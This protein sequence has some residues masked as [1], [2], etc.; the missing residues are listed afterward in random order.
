M[1]N[2]REL[3][4]TPQE[5][6]DIL[7]DLSQLVEVC[8]VTGQEKDL[9]LIL[10]EKL[11]NAGFDQVET[12]EVETGRL[13]VVAFLKGGKPGPRILFTG[14]MDTVPA[15]EGWTLAPFAPTVRDGR[16]YGRG[17]LDMK[18][19]IAAVLS[20]SR[21][22]AAHRESLQ[23]EVL[24]AFVVDEEAFSIGVD[25]LIQ[26]G[27]CADFGIAAEPEYNPMIIG[28]AGKILI[29][30]EITGK[31]AHGSQPEL[32]INAIEDGARFLAALQQCHISAHPDIPSA[33]YVTLQIEGGFK[34]YSIVVPERCT[35]LLNKHTVPGESQDHVLNQLKS[36]V[37]SLHLASQFAFSVETPY[38][39]SY[40]LGKRLPMLERVAAAYQTVTGE[41]LQ[42]GYGAG[43]SDSNRLVPLTGIPVVCLGARGGGLH[44][45]DEWVELSSVYQM[46]EI[47]RRILFDNALPDLTNFF[48]N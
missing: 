42:Y 39:P 9:A 48:T 6:E 34:K 12:Q 26:S 16:L 7:R 8:S 4:C 20:L 31:A 40:D 46:A 32:G 24:I 21:F 17:A 13:N 33:P 23:G 25:R 22:A 28:A 35:I 5:Q 10:V 45:G 27:L 2:R 1:V 15:G 29:R 44:A 43:V 3:Y 11:K 14:H 37:E 30:V 36:V 41:S 19:G 38:Y 18:S 47:Y